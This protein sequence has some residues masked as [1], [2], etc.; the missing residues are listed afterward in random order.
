MERSRAAGT[1]A[2][3]PSS[4]LRVHLAD[5]RT[6][7]GYALHR[8]NRD[9]CFAASG[10]L[11]YTTL[12][13][14]VPLGVIGFGIL[15]AFPKF[16]GVR[17][18]MLGLAFQNFVPAISEQAAYWFQYF[19]GSAAQA[20]A[21]G[22]IG[23]A[24]TGILLLVTV[25]D[26]LNALWRVGAARPWSQRVL[27]YWTLMTLGPLLIGM[28]MTLSTYLDTAARRAG[29][30]PE[31]LTQ[32]AS[33]WPHYLARL[34]PF[35]LEL[36]ACTLLYCVIPNCAIRWRDGVRGA[37]VAAVAIEILKVGFSI[38]IGAMSSYQIVYGA[39][40]GIPIFLLWMYVTWSAVLLGAVVAANLP[41]WRVDERLVHIGSGGVR[42]GFSLALIAALA[43]A[44]QAGAVSRVK[45]LADEL[46]VATSVIDDHLQRLARAG[47][48]APTQGGAWVL[49][50]SLDTATLHDLYIGLGLP[51]AGNWL[52]RPLAPWQRQVAPAMERIVS[53]EAGVMRVSL[54]T[55]L[56]E[57][58][59][60]PPTPIRVVAEAKASE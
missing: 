34:I 20:T 44:Q 30:N 28:S 3:V 33:G 15:S 38:Y 45:D 29:L 6:F 50:W 54:A 17:Q 7:C 42:L 25:E 1:A 9:G 16:A 32:F 60:S 2:E 19:A 41:T 12:V 58:Y 55:V 51:L 43:R 22:I 5:L 11:S 13:S 40:A 14:L 35:L 49:A 37:A 39:I 53:A 46:G 18:D 47:F 4:R 57:V 48:V 10:A 8:F 36:V 56:K 26:Q 24:G 31:T 23:I 59:R 21:I 52:A 27:A